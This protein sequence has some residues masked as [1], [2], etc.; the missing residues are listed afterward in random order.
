MCDE[1][2][3][4]INAEITEAEPVCEKNEAE[5]LSE[6]SEFETELEN[7]LPTPDNTDKVRKPLPGWFW[8]FAVSALTCFVL[9]SIYTALVLPNSRPQT[10]ISY[11]ENAPKEEQLG[12]NTFSGT[13]STIN[14]QVSKSIV[15]IESKSSYRNFFGISS[16]TN[17]GS[18]IIVTQD[19][20]IVTARS[21]IG[22]DGETTVI[23]PDKRKVSASV[24]G[25][26]ANKDVAVIK[27]DDNTLPAVTLGNSD[28]VKAGDDAIVIGNTLGSNLGTSVTKGIICGVN[29]GVTLKNGGTINLFQTDAITGVGSTGGCV[30]NAQ[31]DV[32]GMITS[33]ITSGNENISF[34]I[35]SNDIKNAVESII[36]TG[37]APKPLIIGITGNDTEHG[38]SVESV[39]ENTPAEIAGLKVGD[40]IL[41]V[42]GKAVKSIAEINKIR[43]LH[44]KGDTIVLSIYRDG[45]MLDINIIL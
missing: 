42:D 25:E 5:I 4:E 32:I 34:A 27:I 35:P 20:Y 24:V 3:F 43:D 12:K 2:N 9:F 33:A 1:N 29:N 16:T 26:D 6:K 17:S 31:G 15:T 18:G 21:L 37:E 30:V 22:T 19:G 14:E 41:K 10:V 13:I 8:S 38:V 44:K 28:N 39:M 40:L 36:S 11:S 7:Y 23:L 45:E